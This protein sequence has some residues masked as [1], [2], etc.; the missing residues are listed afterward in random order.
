MSA[1][2]TFDED[3]ISDL[4]KDAYGF[5]PGEYWFKAWATMT[6]DEKQV[7]WDSLVAAMGRREDERKADEQV[8]IKR[9]EQSVTDTIATGASD[10]ATA[11]RWMMDGADANGD[12]EYFEYLNCI[13]FGYV[14]KSAV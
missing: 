5:R 1:V 8:G 10:R 13:P 14:A 4:H 9:F 6:D 3:C 12:V 7:E 11:I 2:Y